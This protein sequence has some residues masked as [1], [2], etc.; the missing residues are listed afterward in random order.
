MSFYGNKVNVIEE[1]IL[2]R[3]DLFRKHHLITHI[4]TNLDV[5]DIKEKYGER[6]L[7]RMYEMFNFIILG[8]DKNATDRRMNKPKM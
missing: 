1:I 8:G 2:D 3:Y 6:V 7:S 4:T 5:E